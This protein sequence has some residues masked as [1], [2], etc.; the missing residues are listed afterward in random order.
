[1]DTAIVWFRRD[2]RLSDN[3]A[4]SNALKAGQQ[5]VPVYIFSPDED[6]AWPMG[7]ASRW[8]LHHS[9]CDLDASLKRLGSRLLIRQGPSLDALR[10]LI[11]E[12]GAKQVYWNRLYEPASIARDKAIKQTIRSEGLAVDS[13]NS[14]L[15]RE[16]WTVANGKSEPY[17][18]F[19]P[20]WKA[21]QKQGLLNSPPLPM[22][23][24]LPPIP[25]D[26][27]SLNVAELG[28]LPKIPWDS[29]LRE[30][31]QPGEAGAWDKLEEF[32]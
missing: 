25:R 30:N 27:A 5:L 21:L 7:S 19:T 18:V 23:S 2:L 6:G 28:L 4:L 10:Q 17:R 8:W 3:P 32:M 16:P 24:T 9:L 1:M 20:Y 13:F 31:W 11:Q 22:P 29:G 14:A 15:L 26:W 12:T